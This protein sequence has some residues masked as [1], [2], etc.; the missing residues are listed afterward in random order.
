MLLSFRLSFLTY[1]EENE[2]DFAVMKCTVP[3]HSIDQRLN[4]VCL[5]RSA[6]D[7][8]DYTLKQSN[9]RVGSTFSVK[10]WLST[11]SLPVVKCVVHV[12]PA[13]LPLQPFTSQLAK[14]YP[15]FILIIFID[16]MESS[17]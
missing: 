8:V 16:P 11:D 2:Y 17:D 13:N 4:C 5:R 1:E 12:L 6:D 7:E 3:L 15:F 10:D 9:A 14:L